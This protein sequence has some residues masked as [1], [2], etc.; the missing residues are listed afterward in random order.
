MNLLTNISPVWITLGPIVVINA[1]LFT[2]YV[3]YQIW[4]RKRIKREFAGAKKGESNFLSSGTREWWFWTT[5]PVV[6]LFVKLRIGPNTI[7]M[8]GFV[9]ACVAAYLF[10]RGSFG[11]AGWMMILSASFD[12][13]DG[14]VARITGK[15]TRS[16]AF[17]DA[18]MDRFGEGACM[19]G[20]GWYFRASFMLP[21]IFAALVG[22]LLVSYT[23][24]RAE[25]VGVECNVGT[26]QRPE[27]IVALGVA[28]VFSPMVGI[29]LT[30]WMPS[31]TPLLV[32]ISLGLIAVLTNF[33][34]IYRMIHV[35]NALDTADRR[36]N[37]SIPQI[38][39]KLG[40]QAGREMLW[41]RARYGYDRSRASY[42]HVVLFAASGISPEVLSAMMR[43]GD[44]PNIALHVA[45]RG[46]FIEAIGAFPSTV[47]PASTP[48][49]TGS[50]PGTCDIP[51]ARWFDRTVQAGRVLAM[52]RFRDYLGWGAYAMDYDLSNSVRTVF[53]YSRQA[54]NIFGMLNRGC[55]LVRDPAFFRMHRRYNQARRP[56]DLERAD[57]AAFYWFSSAI[58]RETDFVLYRFPPMLAPG[59]GVVDSISAEES[60]RRID[61]Y[62][63]RAAQ[64]IK[65]NGMYEQTALIFASDHATGTAARAFDLDAFVGKRF[66]LCNADRR[67]REWIDSDAIALTS[68]TSMAH[69]Y[70]KLGRGWEERCFFED[71]E[72]KGL[73]GSL[74]EQD[75]VDIIAGRSS[76]GGIVVQSRRGRAHILEDADGRITYLARSGDPFGLSGVRQ[77]LSSSDALDATIHSDYPDGIMQ[78]LQIFRS[79]RTGDLVISAASDVALGA[80]AGGSTHG[81]LSRRH[82]VV[83]FL[84]SVP[85]SAREIRTA[86]AFA[87]TLSLMGIDAEHS[88]DGV[89]PERCEA[90]GRQARAT[91]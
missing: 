62:V 91:L 86:D 51:G 60:L 57:E 49:V 67:L 14:R 65:N 55:G 5:D 16:G 37:D 38:I 17:F 71:V 89:V 85:I 31:P 47:G 83:P 88:L 39:T 64:V 75:G 66:K 70:L 82:C 8:I 23:K 22:S 69:L 81:S 40:T 25:A 27:R 59:G 19:L 52:N 9:T 45:E 11:Y 30:R 80:Q 32:M 90:A 63:G 6:R 2:S 61:S 58:R 53:E 42:S 77:V 48:F 46:S 35:M 43:R 54:V 21:I 15:T 87:L 72:R 84:S 29:A 26:M 34:A 4:G 7:T 79:R 36:G 56:E 13:F 1:I 74:L 44:L 33:T 12:I 41:D 76:E 20:L 18:V 28:S 24:A 78:V 73:V 50:F 10:A 3:L 68:G